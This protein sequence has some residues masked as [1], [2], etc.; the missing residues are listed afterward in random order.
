MTVIEILSPGNKTAGDEGNMYRLKR[1]EYL[2]NNISFVEID[3]LRYGFRPPLGDPIPPISDYYVMVHR[4]WE[5]DRLG[6]WPLSIR[7]TLPPIPVPLDPDVADV[8]LDLRVC[9]DQVYDG[10]RYAE[11][12]DYSK[13]PARPLREPD[14]TW[15]H[16]LLSRTSPPQ[17]VSTP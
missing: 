4:G 14:A 10:G 12:L 2:A 17:R 9:I 1:E 6:I 11:Q 8:V 13:P 7:D 5:K 3:L 16:E 15:A